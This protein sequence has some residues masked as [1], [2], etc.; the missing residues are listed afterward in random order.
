MPWG[1]FVSTRAKGVQLVAFNMSREFTGPGR[2]CGG[3]IGKACN[4]M[5][6][7]RGCTTSAHQL[8]PIHVDFPSTALVFISAQGSSGDGVTSVFVTPF[9]TASDFGDILETYLNDDRP[10]ESW[11]TLLCS[12]SKAEP[13]DKTEATISKL[14]SMIENNDDE[15]PRGD[16][17]LKK[18]PELEVR[19][20]ALDAGFELTLME[21]EEDLGTTTEIVI[22][23]IRQEWQKTGRNFMTLKELVE[24]ARDVIPLLIAGTSAEFGKADVEISRI[25]NLIGE[26]TEAMGTMSCFDMI[27]LLGEDLERLEPMENFVTNHSLR[28]EENLT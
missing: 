16:T 27:S 23:N 5:C 21:L 17:P 25:S 26:R 2:R 24:G 6:V 10:R 19:S 3:T 7:V 9:V 12:I 18:R 8:R 20:P 28:W 11:E 13:Q 15:A 4:K 1:G 22:T 14:A